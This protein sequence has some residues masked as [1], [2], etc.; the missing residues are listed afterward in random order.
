MPGSRH[1][2]ANVQ[3]HDRLEQSSTC[4]SPRARPTGSTITVSPKKLKAQR[5]A[6]DVTFTVT[7]TSDAPLGDAAVRRDPSSAVKKG[8][9]T[10]HLPVAFI[11]SQGAVSADPVVRPRDHRGPDATT[12]RCDVA[13]TN[14]GSDE[15]DGQTSSTTVNNAARR[16]SAP[17]APR[18]QQESARPS[19][20][21]PWMDPRPA[22]Q[23]VDPRGRGCRVRGYLALSGFGR[24]PDRRSATRRSSTSTC[25]RSSYGGVTRTPPSASTPTATSSPVVATSPRTTTAATSRPAPT[26]PRRTTCSRPFWTDL[27]GTGAPGIFAAVLTDGG[28]ALARHRVAGRRLRDRRPSA[29]S[30]SGSASTAWR[31]SRYSYDPTDLPGDPAGQDFLVGAENDLG[32]GDDVRHAACRPTD[33]RVVL[34]APTPGRVSAPTRSRSRA[35]VGRRPASLTTTMDAD[36]VLGTD[37]R[38]EHRRQSHRDRPDDPVREA[39]KHRPAGPARGRPFH[40]PACRG[41]CRHACRC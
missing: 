4:R 36:G 32:Q 3:E 28:S 14:L 38:Q 2:R 27:D 8:G 12:R 13:A 17:T 18:V 41:P 20:A 30:S 6:V 22:S 24:R 33:L 15:P 5:R 9:Q 26:R 37:H 1:D 34:D 10:L 11:H 39:T 21:R 19:P 16:S 25:R 31:T 40:I 29:P 35:S 23:P 7:I